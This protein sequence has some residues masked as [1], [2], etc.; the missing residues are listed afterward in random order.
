MIG[1]S[2]Q[3]WPKLGS[4]CSESQALTRF[5]GVYSS[6]ARLKLTDHLNWHNTRCEVPPLSHIPLT[7]LRR[8]LCIQRMRPT[9]SSTLSWKKCL[10]RATGTS[11]W[12][13]LGGTSVYAVA[14]TTAVL[15]LQSFAF[16][17]WHD[18][19]D[20][21]II[22]LSRRPF[23]SANVQEMLATSPSSELEFQN[24]VYAK[25][26]RKL[27]RHLLFDAILSTLYR[28]QYSSTITPKQG[29]I[30]VDTIYPA[31]EKHISKHSAQNFVMVSVACT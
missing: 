30:T 11:S 16:S 14:C 3:S 7:C 26:C 25:A 17:R 20:K 6:V 29:T 15:L 8:H 21:G 22:L 13:F 4:K 2:D 24:D 10:V 23:D 1:T 18:K 27:E 5:A 28:L 12:R 19:P 31:T 9:L